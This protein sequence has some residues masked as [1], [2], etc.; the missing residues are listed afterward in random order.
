MPPSNLPLQAAEIGVMKT[1]E[2]MAKQLSEERRLRLEAEAE[3]QALRSQ[4]QQ[5]MRAMPLE[6]NGSAVVP[7]AS[8][9]GSGSPVTGLVVVS[10]GQNAAIAGQATPGGSVCSFSPVRRLDLVHPSPIPMQPQGTSFGA[11]QQRVKADSLVLSP[12]GSSAPLPTGASGQQASRPPPRPDPSSHSAAAAT[13][14]RAA[15]HREAP[16]PPVLTAPDVGGSKVNPFLRAAGTGSLSGGGNKGVFV[17]GG[18]SV[19]PSPLLPRHN[20]AS[21]RPA[22]FPAALPSTRQPSADMGSAITGA[23]A[24]PEAAGAATALT[25]ETV[26]ERLA[27]TGS[28]GM[29]ARALALHFGCCPPAC[30]W[31]LHQ[32]TQDGS[33][34]LEQQRRAVQLCALLSGLVRDMDVFRKGGSSSMAHEVDL[35]DDST[36]YVML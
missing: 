24:A 33:F 2:R 28:D 17:I 14:V 19:A 29:T 1:E 6:R 20:L 12:L 23:A 34:S 9:T 4:L 16:S 7:R 30:G 36:V 22:Q 21:T 27:A 32:M 31:P 35:S 26:S 8:E 3:L 15:Q 11:P 13:S 25:T 5:Q 10:A 18:S